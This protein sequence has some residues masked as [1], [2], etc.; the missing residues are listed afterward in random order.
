MSCYN[1]MSSTTTDNNQL[2]INELRH[3]SQYL[4]QLAD[5]HETNVTFYN[6][7][8][9]KLQNDNA[10]ITQEN[11]ALSSRLQVL[12]SLSFVKED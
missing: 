6:T 10:R 7:Q 11:R 5:A 3:L 9:Q 1:T 8:L 2:L 12:Q 4:S